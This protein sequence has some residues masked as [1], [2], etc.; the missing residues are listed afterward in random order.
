MKVASPFVA[1]PSGDGLDISTLARDSSGYDGS[2]CDLFSTAARW[3][4]A[5]ARR[6][7]GAPRRRVRLRVGL[8]E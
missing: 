4:F 6:A 2:N 1:L 8:G 5:F 7:A 3:Y